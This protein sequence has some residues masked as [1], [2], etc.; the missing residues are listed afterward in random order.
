MEGFVNTGR[1]SPFDNGFRHSGRYANYGVE[2][3]IKKES[4]ETQNQQERQNTSI[5]KPRQS[6]VLMQFKDMNSFVGSTFTDLTELDKTVVDTV[7]QTKTK[8]N[9]YLQQ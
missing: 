8:S 7:T 1:T 6:D 4:G 5:P 3:Y 9:V 2:T